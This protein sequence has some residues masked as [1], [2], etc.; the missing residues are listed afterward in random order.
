MR[1]TNQRPLGRQG[2]GGELRNGEGF[3]IPGSATDSA[4]I[5]GSTSVEASAKLED[6][7][8]RF[9]NILV[10][11]LQIRPSGP[12]GCQRFTR[13]VQFASVEQQIYRINL[14]D[15]KPAGDQSDLRNGRLYR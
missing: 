12:L 10:T 11:Q 8:N 13:L 15:V 7:L 1:G 14:E 3:M 4:P 9:L 2:L 6:D 5:D